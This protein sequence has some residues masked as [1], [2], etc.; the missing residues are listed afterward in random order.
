MDVTKIVVHKTTK[1]G[2]FKIKKL[3]TSPQINWLA[4]RDSLYNFW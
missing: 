4:V 2:G 1:H 3:T